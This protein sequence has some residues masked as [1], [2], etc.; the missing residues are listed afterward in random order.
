MVAPLVGPDGALPLPWLKAPLQ[1]AL[2]ELRGHATLLHGAAGSGLF[3]LAMTLAQGWLC[4]ALA[5]QG[6]PCGRCTSCHLVLARTHPDLLVLVPDAL[7]ERLGW[8]GDAE[9]EPADGESKS[10]TKASREIRVEAVRQAIGF[11]QQSSARGQGKAI[12]IHPADTMNLV[13]AN[14]LLKTLEEPPGGLRLALTTA[15]AQALLPTLRSRCQALR[16]QVP[17]A[18]EAQAWLHSQGVAE[19]EALLAAMGG[20]PLAV[21]DWLA[22][23]GDAKDWPQVP[24]L[25]ARRGDTGPLTGWPLPRA[26][27][28][29]LKLCHD[30]MAVAAGGM[31]RFYPQGSVPAGASLPA[32]VEWSKALTRASRHDEHPWNAGLLVEALVTQGRRAWSEA[33]LHSRP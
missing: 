1:R 15:S 25:V 22:D 19:P 33:S 29:L 23:G 20:Q 26:I 30:A 8:G 18:S 17:P 24:A 16:L 28:A 3:E 21:L 4:E 10:R 11:S 7:R 6:R 27:D 2:H 9:E 31:P 13:S 14:A 5:G 12:V 32:L